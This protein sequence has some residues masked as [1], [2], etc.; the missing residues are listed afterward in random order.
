MGWIS[1]NS[2]SSATLSDASL[3]GSL[4]DGLIMVASIDRVNKEI[5]SKALNRLNDLG[6]KVLGLVSNECSKPKHKD[7]KLSD[8]YQEAYNIYSKSPSDDVKKNDQYSKESSKTSLV[9][10]Y[11]KKFNEWL[12][13]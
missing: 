13:N 11:L 7:Q 6:N 5:F 10:K 1:K 12:D 2:P 9:S 3:V 4:C 8:Q